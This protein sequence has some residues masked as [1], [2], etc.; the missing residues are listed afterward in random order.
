MNKLEKIRIFLDS[1]PKKNCGKPNLIPQSPKVHWKGLL[2]KLHGVPRPWPPKAR[3]SCGS[4]LDVVRATVIRF[5]GGGA[6]GV[7]PTGGHLRL[8]DG[9]CPG[10]V[11]DEERGQG[12]AGHGRDEA[13]HS[14]PTLDT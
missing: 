12:P 1:E 6:G 9:L 10:E 8:Q 5:G 7:L 13:T 14:A 2:H 11:P 3:Q 4:I